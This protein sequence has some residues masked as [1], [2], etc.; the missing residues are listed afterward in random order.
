M[1]DWVKFKSLSQKWSLQGTDLW[2]L[3]IAKTL[4]LSLAES[5]PTDDFRHLLYLFPIFYNI[6][7]IFNSRR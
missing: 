1:P 5:H 2:H 6:Y 7:Q 3:V 4:L